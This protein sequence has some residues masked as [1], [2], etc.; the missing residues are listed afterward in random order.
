MA[1][2]RIS[3]EIT[4]AILLG[5]DDSMPFSQCCAYRV[6]MFVVFSEMMLRGKDVTE[7]KFE[8]I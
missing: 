1:A 7:K 4:E 2:C 5:I 3:A 6:K 8:E